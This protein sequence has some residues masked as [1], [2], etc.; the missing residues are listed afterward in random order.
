M[1]I[2]VDFGMG[3]GISKSGVGTYK[4]GKHSFN[5]TGADTYQSWDCFDDPN[6]EWD[7]YLSR[8]GN[9]ATFDLTGYR[10]GNE[11]CMAVLKWEN[12]SEHSDSGIWNITLKDPDDNIIISITD[13]WSMSS[14]YWKYAWYGIGVKTLSGDKEIWKNGTYTFEY[15]ITYDDDTETETD[16][17]TFDVYSFPSVGSYLSSKKGHIWIEGENIAFICYQGYK[18][19]VKHDGSSSYIDSDKAGTIWVESDGRIHYIDADRYERKT[20][21]G[22][23]YGNPD[24]GSDEIPD[25][26]E[27]SYEGYIWVSNSF[28]DTYLMVVTQDGIK[29]RIGV[30]YVDSGDYQ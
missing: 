15:T 3:E 28:D 17:V 6:F 30:G 2:D 13:D 12:L 10:Y 4:W 14:G 23:K 25:S 26:P 16:S 5:P 11:V 21:T 22:D 7:E 19:V 1:T 24:Q 20:K 8:Y 9:S 27:T 18:I 29:Y